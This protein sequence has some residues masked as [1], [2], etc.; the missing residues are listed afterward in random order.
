MTILPGDYY[1][2]AFRDSWF[3]IYFLGCQPS[4]LRLFFTLTI[5]G[6]SFQCTDALDPKQ[7]QILE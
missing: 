5:S 3:G 1:V 7:F 6:L 4:A 2:K